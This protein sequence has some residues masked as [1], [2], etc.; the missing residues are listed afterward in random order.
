MVVQP[1]SF[2]SRPFARRRQLPVFLL[3]CLSAWLLTVTSLLAGNFYAGTTPATVPWPGGIVPYEFTNTLTAAQQQTYFDGLR[4]WELAAN[5]TFVPHTN[6]THWILFTYNTNWIDNVSP[7][8]NPQVVTVSS[9]SRA[10]VC[11]E[12]GHSFGFTH[13]NIRPDQTNYLT[14]FPANVTSGNLQFF[15]IDPTSVTNGPYDFESVMHLGWDFASIQPG[16]LATWAIS[17][18]VP[19]TGLR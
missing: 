5:V 19:A 7:G 14:V 12:M 17:A 1:A 6:Q 13:E 15:Q 4:E 10:Q 8:T 18:S 16:V 3:S 9:L 11:H 2:G